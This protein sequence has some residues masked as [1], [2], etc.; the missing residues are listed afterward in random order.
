M[1]GT[2]RH[3]SA[4]RRHVLLTSAPCFADHSMAE[5]LTVF[6]P[7][8]VRTDQRRPSPVAA[9]GHTRPAMQCRI[10]PFVPGRRPTDED[11]RSG[12]G[13]SDRV[14]LVTG[15]DRDNRAVLLFEASELPQRCCRGENHHRQ[16][17]SRVG[18]GRVLFTRAARQ[19]AELMPERDLADVDLGFTQGFCAPPAPELHVLDDGAVTVADETSLDVCDVRN[20]GTLQTSDRTAR[21]GRHESPS[22]RSAGRGPWRPISPVVSRVEDHGTRLRCTPTPSWQTSLARSTT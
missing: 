5:H 2:V 19:R 4:A 11:T 1:I 3:G 8:S 18:R 20:L 14:A 21:S 15:E 10:V 13:S 16:P 17:R 12:L 22:R 6:M 7:E 9:C